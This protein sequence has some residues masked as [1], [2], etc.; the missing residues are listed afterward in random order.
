MSEKEGEKDGPRER[1]MERFNNKTS[2]PPPG[3]TKRLV[4]HRIV[5]SVST[6]RPFA[7]TTSPQ[8]IHIPFHM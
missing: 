1:Q 2:P 8:A 7:V 5:Q 4:G 6:I 3:V